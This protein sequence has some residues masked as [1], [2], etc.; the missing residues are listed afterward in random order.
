MGTQK[1]WFELRRSSIQGKGAFALRD[2]P[3][4]TRVI[5]YTGE[6]ISAEEASARYDDSRAKRHHTFLFELGD[7]RC[8]DAKRIGNDARYINHSCEPNCEARQEGNRIFIY[9]RKQ[10]PAGA[11]LTYDYQYVIDG[12]LD[13][14]TR[15][16]YACKCGTRKCR[17][18]IAV[19]RPRK[20][21]AKPAKR[22]NAKSSKTAKTTRSKRTA[23][24]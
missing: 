3:K 14:E 20:K 11:E 1:P 17:G 18:T 19:A 24:R 5:E 2:I 9:A 6:R 10:I 4:D 16:L 13:A 12:P 23:S 21:L 15:A 8:I 7:E 22:S